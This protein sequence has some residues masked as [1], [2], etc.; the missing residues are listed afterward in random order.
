MDFRYGLLTNDVETTSIQLNK[1][2]DDTGYKVWKEGMPRLLD[3]YAK[4]HI[5]STFFFTGYIARLYP[6]VVKMI[7]S[8]DHEVACHGLVHDVDKAFDVLSLDDQIKHLQKSKKILEDISGEEVVSFRA[9]ALRINSDTAKAL[10]YSGFRID[11]SIAPQRFDFFLSFGGLKKIKWLTLPRLPYKTS[12]VSLFKPGDSEIL[13]IPLNA[14]LMPYIG[15]TMRIFPNVSR[16]LR[17]LSHIEYRFHAKPIVFL[18][19]PN[20]L[21]DESEEVLGKLNKRSKNFFSYLLADKIRHRLK[22]KNLGLNALQLY[23]EHIEYFAKREYKFITL[24]EFA[25][26]YNG[27]EE[28]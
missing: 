16:I 21:I 25:R 22:I 15:T 24:K 18:I 13:E 20:E 11:S 8:Y 28:K 14:F 17:N 27:E 5:K 26:L 6:E 4:Y 12:S 9:P 7:Q 10:I 23:E 1:L 19:H 3:L 2:S